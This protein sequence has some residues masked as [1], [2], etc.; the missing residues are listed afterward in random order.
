MALLATL[1]VAAGCANFGGSESS[2]DDLN[3]CLTKNGFRVTRYEDGLREL[4]SPRAKGRP[5]LRAGFDKGNVSDFNEIALVSLGSTH[6]ANAVRKDLAR[7]AGPRAK[8]LIVQHEEI[9]GYWGGPPT[10]K[11]ASALERCFG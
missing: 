10:T 11:P 7:F 5:G 1:V 8:T 3:E 2:L 9:V 4:T 6:D